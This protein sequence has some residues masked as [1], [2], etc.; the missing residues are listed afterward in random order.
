MLTRRILG[1]LSVFLRV[2]L[3][4]RNPF[5]LTPCPQWISYIETFFKKNDE[6]L[7]LQMYSSTLELLIP[8]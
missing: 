2:L 1:D 3:I 8:L 4:Q 7:I 5:L 6:T